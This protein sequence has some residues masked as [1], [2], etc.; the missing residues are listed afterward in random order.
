LLLVRDAEVTGRT[1]GICGKKPGNI[2]SWENSESLGFVLLGLQHP[3]NIPYSIPSPNNEETEFVF[4]P[5][6]G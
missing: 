2:L 1:I 6:F 4:R 3:L 5:N